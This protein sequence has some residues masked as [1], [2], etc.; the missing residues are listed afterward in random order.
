MCMPGLS[1]VQ[2]RRGGCGPGQPCSQR[3][4]PVGVSRC[5]PRP[6]SGVV[7]LEGEANPSPGAAWAPLL[8]CSSVP[9]AD[10]LVCWPGSKGSSSV[11]SFLE[12]QER[13]FPRELCRSLSL[14]SPRHLLRDAIRFRQG[15]EVRSDQA[16]RVRGRGPRWGHWSVRAGAA[17]RTSTLSPPWCHL[18][19]HRC[20]GGEHVSNPE[21]D[22][23]CS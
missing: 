15:H 1:P 4:S 14:V 18:G 2:P 8:P 6:C 5:L 10:L 23:R 17:A 7:R 20:A 12:L 22:W 3:D 9:C 19:T 13:E 21:Q 16:G 11:P